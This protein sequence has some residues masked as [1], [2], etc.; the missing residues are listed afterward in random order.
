M[1]LLAK[2]QLPILSAFKVTAPQSSSNRKIHLYI[3]Y[4]KNKPQALPKTDVL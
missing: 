3:K 4:R 2:L 1:Y